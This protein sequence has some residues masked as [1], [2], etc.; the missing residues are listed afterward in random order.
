[1]NVFDII[2][3]IPLL[4]AAYKG[5]RQ[6]TAVQLAGLAGLFVGV[7]LAFRYGR[8]FGSWLH[9]DPGSLTL[10]NHNKKW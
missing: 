8:D 2:V 4:Y 9:I 1:M 3:G 7:Y 5:F 10:C 6:G